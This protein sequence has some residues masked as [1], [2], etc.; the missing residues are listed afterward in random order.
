M[1]FTYCH[2]VFWSDDQNPAHDS[3]HRLSDPG[4]PLAHIPSTLLFFKTR[5][6]KIAK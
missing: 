5:G 3:T 1:S 4:V 6:K 2:G